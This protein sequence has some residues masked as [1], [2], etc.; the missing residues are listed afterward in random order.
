MKICVIGLDSAAPEMIVGDERLGNLRRLMDIGLYGKL[1]GSAPWN[2]AL[3]DELTRA[4]KESVIIGIA[5]HLRPTHIRRDLADGSKATELVAE[6]PIEV[7]DVAADQKDQLRDEIFELS[8]K[9]WTVVKQLLAEEEWDYFHFVDTGMDL[10]Q[11]AF[12][13]QDERDHSDENVISDY[14]QMIDEQIAGVMEMLDD[15]TILIVVAGSAEH[16]AS[17]PPIF[18]LAAPNCPIAGEYEGAKLVDIAPTLLDLAGYPIPESME[19]RSLV[20]GMEKVTAAG[21]SDD[22]LLHDRLAGL[23][24]V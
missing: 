2:S 15:K 23:G 3:L 17:E 14:Y 13:K 18:L 1:E 6:Y 20:A 24:Y 16:K 4:G 22:Q 7:K 8:R 9:Q 21:A 5:P 11:Q 19:G 12:S 10:V